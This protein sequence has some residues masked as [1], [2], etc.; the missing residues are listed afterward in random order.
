MNGQ[1]IGSEVNHD[2]RSRATDR[3]QAVSDQFRA[4]VV[5]SRPSQGGA[6]KMT[7][8]VRSITDQ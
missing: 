1:E 4:G 2:A 7:V 5:F 3:L 6:T 8:K